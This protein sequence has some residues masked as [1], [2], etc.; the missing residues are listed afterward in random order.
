MNLIPNDD[1]LDVEEM[2]FEMTHLI[3][4][5]KGPDAAEF[6][7]TE[8]Q[9]FGN[10]FT[11]SEHLMLNFNFFIQ[12]ATFQYYVLYFG[13]SILG[14]ISSDIYYSF[15]LLDVINRSP[16]L[17]NVMTAITQNIV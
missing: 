6:N 17:Q 14:Y 7:L 11:T 13:I 3:L 1:R 12:D 10:F 16:D 4:M 15:H 2:S 9:T 5:L 8:Q